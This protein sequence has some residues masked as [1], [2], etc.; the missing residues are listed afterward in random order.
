MTS[1]VT[2]KPLK[3]L[4]SVPTSQQSVWTIYPLLRSNA[5]YL[6]SPQSDADWTLHADASQLRPN[7]LHFGYA[8]VEGERVEEREEKL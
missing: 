2:N 5:R 4:S 6:S 3:P 7:R 8:W 1:L